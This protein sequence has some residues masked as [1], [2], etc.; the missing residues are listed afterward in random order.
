[1]R[2]CITTGT[3][4]SKDDNED[5]LI[6]VFKNDDLS[7]DCDPRS[8]H[9]Q[10]P[11]GSFFALSG[12]VVG[13]RA[14]GRLTGVAAIRSGLTDLLAQRPLRDVAETLEG[15]FLLVTVNAAGDLKIVADRFGRAELFYQ[16]GQKSGFSAASDMQLLAEP[17]EAQGY[18][19][20]A[21]VHML[22]NYGYCPPKRH[23]IYRG[24]RR[25]GVGDVL[26][27]TNGTV[28]IDR[29]TFVPART[30]SY[31]VRDRKRYTEAFLD[32]L[33]NAGSE[34]GNVVCLSSGWDSTSI[35]AGLVHIFGAAKVRAVIGRMQYSARSGVCN[36]FE[37][38]RAKAIAEYFGVSLE[39]VDFEYLENGPDFFKAQAP[40]MKATQLY[41]FNILTHGQLASYTRNIAR[42]GEVVFA[43]EISDGAHNLGFSQY[44]TIF[45]PSF[46]FR[47]YADKMAG[48][49]FGPTFYQRLV[50]G[51]QDSDPIYALFKQR[52]PQTVYDAPA[53]GK[54]GISLQLLTSF[55]LRNGRIP[56]WSAA[57][58]GMIT[59]LGASR[60]TVAMQQEYLQDAIA[61]FDESTLYA[62]YLYLYNSFHWQGSTVRT[63]S[64]FA[65]DRG[66]TLDMPFWDS[67]VQ[68]FLS[69]MPEEWGRGLDLNST[70][71]PLKAMLREDIDYPLHLQTGPHS[72]TYDVDHSFNHSEEI[73]AHSPFAAD[74]KRALEG[75]PYH[76]LLSKEYFK[77]DYIDDIVDRYCGDANVSVAELTEIAP[78]AILCLIGWYGKK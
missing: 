39:I 47:E 25:L 67:T 37:M 24:V 9:G 3:G 54:D 63:L 27:V 74:L 45:H 13:Y 57:N 60:Y 12:R 36:Q 26:T 41:S 15:R 77:L 71:Y 49:L 17:P 38:D 7:V 70:K 65:D 21:L 56:M 73:M 64:T 10:L 11:D 50:G 19:Q 32:R 43:G 14:N 42:D 20:E 62:W 44:A 16:T 52:S 72:Y 68:D 58:V 4:R 22:S 40:L 46:G 28:S 33:R 6:T 29:K 23:T 35:L 61:T 1:M 2:I 31:T 75:R 69:E 30:G 5:R 8:M 34:I 53:S 59:E 48:Y 66:L 18:D 55:F 78:L 76:R 51:D